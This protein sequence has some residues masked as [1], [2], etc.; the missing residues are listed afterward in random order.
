MYEEEKIRTKEATC[1]RGH[2][3]KEKKLYK[4]TD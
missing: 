2:K 3:R 1:Q 4:L